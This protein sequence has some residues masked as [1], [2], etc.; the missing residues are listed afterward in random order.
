MFP[1]PMRGPAEREL[2]ASPSVTLDDLEDERCCGM[3]GCAPVEPYATNLAGFASD[4]RC[5][6]QSL[7]MIASAAEDQ[8]P[9]AGVLRGV[10]GDQ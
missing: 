8:D 3:L 7:Q 9:A 10:E 2:S 6:D 1:A 4:A 5:S